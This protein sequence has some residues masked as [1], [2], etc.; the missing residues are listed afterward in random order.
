MNYVAE[1]M[2][3]IVARCGRDTIRELESYKNLFGLMVA[4]IRLEEELK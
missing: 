4:K 1:G 2:V 3:F